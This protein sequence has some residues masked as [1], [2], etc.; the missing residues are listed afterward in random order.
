[1]LSNSQ[2]TRA[3]PLLALAFAA[4]LAVATGC[5]KKVDP[6]AEPAGATTLALETWKTDS[7]DCGGGDCADWYRF[8]AS[9]PGHASVEVVTV[10]KEGH[11]LP[12]YALTLT[13]ETG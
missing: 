8:E 9:D 2:Q 13:N 11:S 10:A 7:L 3:N 12:P 1:M 6:D 5:A 4:T